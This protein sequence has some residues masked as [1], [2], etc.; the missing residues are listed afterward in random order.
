MGRA[1]EANKKKYLKD[2]DNDLYILYKCIINL[3]YID[4]IYVIPVFNYIKDKNRIPAFKKFLEYFENNYLKIYPLKNWNYFDCIENTTNNCC[5]SYNNKLNSFFPKKPTFFKLLYKLREEEDFIMKEHQ[6][7]FEGIWSSKRRKL[8]GRADEKDIY[9]RFYE[10][11]IIEIKNVNPNVSEE[12]IIKE[13][14]ICLKKL[15]CL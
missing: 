8:G 3:A 10:E 13:W 14:F 9:V 12:T 2:D 6:R 7:L 15:S 11:K 4:P 5:E 1:L